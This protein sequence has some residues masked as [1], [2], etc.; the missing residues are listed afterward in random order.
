MIFAGSL[1]LV[2]VYL[3]ARKSSQDFLE[4]RCSF[5]STEYSGTHNSHILLNPLNKFQI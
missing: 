1:F 2:C 4:S 3:N 5:M